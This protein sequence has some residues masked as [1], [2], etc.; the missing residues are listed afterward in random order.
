MT[1]ATYAIKTRVERPQARRCAFAAQTTMY[2]GKRIAAGDTI[3]VFASE[4]GSHLCSA[5]HR[6]MRMPMMKTT[7]EPSIWAV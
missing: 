2:G 3:F 5:H 6:L 4:T 7:N 1:V